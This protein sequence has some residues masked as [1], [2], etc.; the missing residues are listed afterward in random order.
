MLGV[1]L[2]RIPK[3]TASADFDQESVAGLERD[4]TGGFAGRK[5]LPRTVFANDAEAVRQRIFAAVQSPGSAARSFHGGLDAAGRAQTNLLS[6]A[7]SAAVFAGAAGVL[8]QLP[9]GD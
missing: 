5:S 2:Q 8:P 7:Q 9:V 4:M 3:A 6:D 1:A